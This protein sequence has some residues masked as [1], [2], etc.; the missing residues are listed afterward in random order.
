MPA[1]VSREQQHVIDGVRLA[2]FNKRFESV[3]RKMA[4]T[5]LRTGRSGV[6]NMARDFSCCIVTADH[7]LVTA[8]ECYP[9]H[10]LRG[11]D[12]MSRA[13]QEFHPTLKRGDAFL[14]NSPYH[15]N[16]HA[17]D[18]AI[19]VPVIDDTGRH[20]FT[21][22]AKAHQA[23][24]GNS[25]PT[26][27]M[28]AARDVY[29]E[30]ALIFPAVKIQEGYRDIH[31]VI[32]MC[33]MRIRVPEQWRGDYLA[34]L[35]AA[36]VGERAMMEMGAELGWDALAEY[37]E[38]LFDYSE[39]LMVQAIRGMPSGIATA[40][41]THDP[42]PG[43]PPEGITIQATVTVD[44]S[45]AH[46]TIDM[47][48][49]PDCYP[50]GL[51]LSQA[52]ALTAAMVGV[53][54]TVGNV[55]PPNAGSF[56]RVEILIREGCVVGIP[57]H[58]TSCSVATTNLGDRVT[59]AVQRA[60]AEIGGGI[61]MADGGAAIPAA[62]AVISGRD[63]RFGDAPFCNEVILGGG[64]GPGTPVSDGWLTM[65]TMGNAGMPFLDSIEVDEIHHPIRIT[66]RRL[67]TDSEGAGKYR[68]APGFQIE[69]GPVRC[70]MEI[71]YVS[72]GTL[73]PAKGARGGHSAAPAR[74]WV[75]TRDGSLQDVPDI[76]AQYVLADGESVISCTAGGGG[77]G[78]P[79]DRHPALVDRDV[80][81]GWI[82]CEKAEQ[83]YTVTFRSDGSVD[84][85]GTSRLR[86]QA[87]N[88]ARKEGDGGQNQI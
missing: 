1:R 22:I 57:R 61:G 2:I 54:N 78:D 53:F 84:F 19:L 70:D 39:T 50:C 33:E 11:A 49:N 55:V 9:I 75:R 29:Q 44:S 14:H 24:C 8:A 15:G 80:R 72:D 83:V 10:V 68:G 56:R 69:F 63:P 73:N 38:E 52:C 36:R 42:V 40:F 7:E 79:R 25:L 71:G 62:G 31:D 86:G 60:L 21:V 65:L 41:A 88:L 74:H 66:E 64:G 30:G 82:S 81:E 58:P 16:S 35:G 45:E 85:D 47:C 5:L 12:L 48:D 26:T 34:T 87:G 37:T 17:A 51:N 27:Y 13:V 59:C 77:Y 43:T 46:I 28:G 32:R 4:N 6:L 23:D 67:I 20:R 3:V 76:S 18:H